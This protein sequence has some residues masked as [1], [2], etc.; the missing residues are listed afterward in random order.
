MRRIIL[1]CV[2][3]LF[4]SCITLQEAEARRGV[5]PIPCTGDKVVKIA[6]LPEGFRHASGVKIDLGYVYHGCFE[7][8][9]VGYVGSSDTYISFKPEMLMAA[10]SLAGLGPAPQ[11]PG[12][13]K[14]ALSHPGQFW[15]EWLWVAILGLA[16]FGVLAKSKD[17]DA[18]VNAARPEVAR[19]PVAAAIREP[20]TA[21]RAPAVRMP[22]VT[23][24]VPTVRQQ[25]GTGFGRRRG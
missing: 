24:S 22:R 10:G 1:A 6:D 11:P 23:R 12:V 25:P 16:P 20:V 13:W 3:V 5:V 21:Q 18:V 19:A 7:G 14:A 15:A 2:A 4:A 9:W 17:K 8:E